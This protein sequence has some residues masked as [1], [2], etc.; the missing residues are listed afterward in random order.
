MTTAATT[1]THQTDLDIRP[2]QFRADDEQLDDLRDRLARTR[3]ARPAPGDSWDYGVTESYLRSMVAA[4]QEFDWR[5]VEDRINVHPNYLADIDGQPVHFLH[6]RANVEGATPLLLAH[7]YPGSVLDYLDLI[8]PLTDPKAHGGTDADAFDVVIPSMPGIGFSQPLVGAGWT[9]AR[10]ARVY[11]TLMRGLG[12]QSYGV[13]GS[14]MGALLARD[15][16]LLEPAGFLGA[17][18]LQ[19]FSFPSGDPAEFAQFGEKDHR[20]LEFLQWF[21]SVGGYNSMN[22]TRPQTIGAALADSPVGQLAY[23]ELFESF[24]NGTSLVPRDQV[25]AQVTLYWLTNSA[26]AAARYYYEDQRAGA[27]STVSHGRIGVVV[28]KDDFQTI[29]SLAERDNTGITHWSELPRGG[30]YAAQEVPADL[31]ADLRTFFHHGDGPSS[32]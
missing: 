17:H 16:V 23:N 22:A 21:Q 11:D 1:P 25:L 29:R 27:P 31:A 5:A 32:A 9:I 7:T 19:L 14:D 26:A 18:V 4:W 24:G 12:Y 28:F 13:H 15:L 6:V 10:T 20:A 3:F 2:F 30:H 8:G